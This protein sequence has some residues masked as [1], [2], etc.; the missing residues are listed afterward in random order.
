MREQILAEALSRK[1]TRADSTL[2]L[3][4]QAY[5]QDIVEKILKAGSR[6]EF[7]SPKST[8]STLC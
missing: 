2:L 7:L 3:A 4:E 8:D 6:P 1:K 5:R